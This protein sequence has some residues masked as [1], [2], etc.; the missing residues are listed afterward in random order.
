MYLS[1][2]QAFHKESGKESTRFIKTNLS[3]RM[4]ILLDLGQFLKRQKYSQRRM[5]H[6][7]LHL[8][9]QVVFTLY[10][11]HMN[12][13]PAFRN[14]PSME[15]NIKYLNHSLILVMYLNCSQ[16]RTNL[17]VLFCLVLS[18]AC[19]VLSEYSQKLIPLYQYLNLT[20]EYT[21]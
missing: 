19:F 21:S 11:L 14:V 10:H 9:V 2:P 15:R 7:H 3:T 18:N 16:Y 12:H 1:S 13:P 6:H 4:K 5:I 8:Q 17:S 20:I